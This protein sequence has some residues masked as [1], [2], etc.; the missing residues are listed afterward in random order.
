MAATA[1]GD[2]LVALRADRAFVDLTSWRKVHVTGFE[3][4]GWLN[5]LITADIA[6]L[7]PGSSRRSLLLT[8][9]GRIRA[10]FHVGPFEEGFL[11]VQDLEQPTAIDVLLAPYVL[12]SD[13]HLSDRTAELA[14]YAC[15]G[16]EPS[17]DV[18]TVA[19]W[20]P[21]CLGPGTDLVAEA[22]SQSTADPP[23]ALRSSGLTE[24]GLEA[25][26]A[27]RVE[28][29]T[30]RFGVDLLEDSLPQEAALDHAIGYGKGCFLGQ[31]AVAKVRNL[32]HAPRVLL[33]AITGA[34]VGPGDAVLADGQEVGLVTSATRLPDGRTA[35]IVRVRW[36][37]KTSSL[38]T[39]DG[40]P[41][42]PI[43]PAGGP[44][45]PGRPRV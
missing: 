25:L 3:A 10:D 34:N 4:R 2:G 37:A 19:S 30:P 12:S 29:G 13:V 26:E 11:L 20:R 22:G 17:D 8:P 40:T 16:R 7:E 41:I 28:Q 43:G 33:P 35:A 32:G 45:E 5:D 21:S 27:W 14:L 39:A 9:T 31:E 42:D 36:A 44:P 18:P 38:A 23:A 1:T 24:A 6:T 15:P